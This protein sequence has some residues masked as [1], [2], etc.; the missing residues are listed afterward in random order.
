[1]SFRR[2]LI[3]RLWQKEFGLTEKEWRHVRFS[4]SQ[5]GED[6]VVADLLP[7]HGF[8]LDVG[9]YHPV[10]L[11]NTYGLYRFRGWRGILIE[12]NPHFASLLQKRRPRDIVVETAV[13]P[14]EGLVQYQ[15][16]AKYHLGEGA[17]NGVVED[18][19]NGPLPIPIKGKI[20]EVQMAPLQK[21]LQKHLPQNQQV[22]FMSIDAEGMD[23]EILRT[24]DWTL[25]QPRVIAVEAHGQNQ[26]KDIDAFLVSLGYR[27][28]AQMIVTLIYARV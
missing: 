13:G 8:Y 28:V 26:E 14:R 10:H 6:L 1:M 2:W 18:L 23:L 22:D 12:P 11:S 21:I 24:N 7:V 15:D 17:A 20:I 9:A 19:I 5:F 3:S 25:C 4:F 16:C 27:R